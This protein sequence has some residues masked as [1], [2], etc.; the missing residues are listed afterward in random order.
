MKPR[1][2][3]VVLLSGGL[4][5]A[6]AAAML[7][8]QGIDVEAIFFRL[9]FYPISTEKRCQAAEV[10][11][12]LGIKLRIV[13]KDREFIQAVRK[14]KHGYG[15]GLNPC[16]DCKIL[17]LKEAKRYAEEVG[18]SFIATGE[19]LGERP[20]SQHRRAL[21]IIERETGLKGRILRPLSAKLLPETDV[22]KDGTVEREKL[23][24]IVGRQRRRQL[25]TAKILG[26]TR[27]ASPAGGCLLTDRHFSKRLRDLFMNSDRVTAR[28][29]KLLKIGRHFRYGPNKIIVGRNEEENRLLLSLKRKSEYYFEVVECGSPITLLQG[30]VSEAATSMAAA[31]TAHYSDSECNPTTVMYGREGLEKKIDVPPISESDIS[32]LRI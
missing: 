1:K 30:P 21:E 2:K 25:E 26:V 20:M 24:D 9:P 31:L 19:V 13:T 18:A 4:D 15:R 14:P 32:R 6:L 11:R 8:K 5:S 10:A 28:D 23:L 16:I 3:A 12:E 29:I 27:Y 22:E 7:I 17:M